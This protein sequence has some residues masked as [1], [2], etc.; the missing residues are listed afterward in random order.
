VVRLPIA[1]SHTV[2]GV[3]ILLTFAGGPFHLA[4]TAWIVVIA[5]VTLYLPVGSLA[6][7]SSSEQVGSDLREA[8]AMSG[9][10]Y[11]RTLGRVV[12]PLVA[13]GLAAGWLLIFVLSVG[14]STVTPL[15]SSPKTPFISA[16]MFDALTNGT[17]GDIA[18][19]CV[20]LAL[21][22]GTVILLV[23]RW[24]ARIGRERR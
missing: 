6:A 11:G 19:V 10:S 15:L 9:S 24:V 17:Y 18:A 5:Y 3:A 12:L 14:E 2:L 20:V 23:R 7:A 1:V 22:T 4:S 16:V 21:T 13:P 8:A